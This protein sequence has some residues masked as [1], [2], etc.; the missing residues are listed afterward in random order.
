MFCVFT[1]HLYDRERWTCDSC[2]FIDHDQNI[3]RL[4]RIRR[5]IEFDCPFTCATFFFLLFV[6]L[7]GQ[8]Y[9]RIWEIYNTVFLY[10]RAWSL[11]NPAEE[12]FLLLGFWLMWK[13]LR[14]TMRWEICK[15]WA[16][17]KKS[18][19]SFAFLAIIYKSI[20]HKTTS[21]FLLLL[22]IFFLLHYS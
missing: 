2:S 4:S 21:I 14:N 15:K 12:C 9:R 7:N 10:D 11:S 19:V 16:N 3:L 18:W 8:K 5:F 13:H 20:E 22:I 1:I 17:W 6:V